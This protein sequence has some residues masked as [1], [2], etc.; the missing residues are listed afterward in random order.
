MFYEAN[1]KVTRVN[2]NGEEKQVIERYV[3]K[4]CISFSE[5]EERTARTYADYSMEGEVV[6]IKRS[7]LYEIVNENANKE[8][9]F[10]AK[11]GSIFIDENSGK[12]KMTYYHVLLSADNMDEA[13][14]I[15]REYMN[16]G[17]SDFILLEIKESKVTDLI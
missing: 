5:A 9:Y 13:Q 16:Q 4:D 15:M 3:I 2:E 14:K 12:E 8:N 1:T 10:R 6:A 7:N 11:L 17:M